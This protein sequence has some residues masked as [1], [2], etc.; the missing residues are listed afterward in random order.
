MLTSPESWAILGGAV[1]L[2]GGVIGSAIGIA[3]AGSAGLAT[4]A[5]D[6]K[7]FKNVIILASI[8]MSQTFYGLITFILILTV[9]VPRV[10]ELGGGSGFS[11]L[12][13][14]IIAAVA[15]CISA[16]WKGDVLASGIVMLPKTKGRI[17]TNSLMLAVFVELIGVLGL[18]FTILALSMLGLF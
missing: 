5:A 17:L 15:F 11:V 10:A 4:L 16:A 18:V 14:G 9:V 8:P 6:S 2:A 3:I 12:A 13:C 7:Q 1:A